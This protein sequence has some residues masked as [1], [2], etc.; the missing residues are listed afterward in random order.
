MGIIS[1]FP[2]EH[3]HTMYF[4]ILSL[5]MCLVL[6]RFIVVCEGT[7]GTAKFL[8]VE[9]NPANITNS[10][11]NITSGGEDYQWSSA[12]QIWGQCSR[13]KPCNFGYGDC[14]TDSDCNP[15]HELVCGEHNCLDFNQKA[16]SLMDCCI[17]KD[18]RFYSAGKAKTHYAYYLGRYVLTKLKFDKKCYPK[19]SIYK[20][21]F[22]ELYLFV[23]CLN[24]WVID[25]KVNPNKAVLFHLAN[26]NYPVYMGWYYHKPG[27]G[28]VKDDTIR[29]K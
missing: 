3:S 19:S 9:T 5:S 17:S 25:A 11:D 15:R 28:V 4:Q 2:I 1:L 12:T 29:V 24:H 26:S 22:K 14:N 21:E 7:R 10:S 16:H 18:Y 13:Y 23:N 20:H 27:G 8:L 6:Y